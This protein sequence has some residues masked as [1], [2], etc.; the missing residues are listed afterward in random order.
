MR[1]QFPSEVLMANSVSNTISGGISFSGVSSGTD[2]TA[3]IEQLKQIEEI[4]KTRMTIWQ[5]EWEYRIAAMEEV[6]SVMSEGKTTLGGFDSVS[7]LMEVS[8]DSSEE[9]VATASL[10]LNSDLTSGNYSIDVKQVATPSLLSTKKIFDEK[11]TII[12]DSSE[13]LE[14]EYTYK[15]E[16]RTI[17]AHP[18]TTLDQLVMRINNDAQNPGVKASLIKNGDGYMFQIQGNDTGVDSELTIS[19]NLPDFSSQTQLF[20]GQDVLLNTTGSAKSYSV[21][22][23]G[24]TMTFDIGTDMTAEQFVEKFNSNGNNP[25]LTASL[26]RSGNDYIISYKD[27]KSGYSAN[28]TV[29]TEISALGGGTGYASADTVVNN[30]GTV[31]TLTYEYYGSNR[32]IQVANGATLQ[33]I[34][35]SINADPSN[36]S[37][38]EQLVQ[39]SVVEKD[40]KYVLDFITKDA[41]LHPEGATTSEVKYLSDGV[42]Y[43]FD[44]EGGTSVKDYIALFNKS[45][46][47]MGSGI[48]AELVDNKISYYKMNLG[49]KEVVTSS[50][51][52]E[53]DIPGVK[54]DMGFTMA[55]IP[56]D[57]NISSKLEG[58][59]KREVI[60]GKNTVVNTSGA[61][62]SYSFTHNGNNYSASVGNNATLEDFV[63]AFNSNPANSTL[64]ARLLEK[65][66]GYELAYFDMATG[67]QIVPEN[68]NTTMAHL[69]IGGDNWY[70]QESQDAIFSINGWPNEIT[71]SSNTLTEVIEGMNITIK[72][73]GETQLSIV[74][75]YTAMEENIYEI[76][77]TINLIKGTILKLQ[78]VDEEKE[79]NSPNSEELS[80]QFTWQSGAALTGNYG[81]QLLLSNFNTITSSA[82]EGFVRMEDPEDTLNDLYTALS[83]IGISTVTNPAEEDFGLLQV[84]TT[85]LQEAIEKDPLAIAE[86]FSAQLSGTTNSQDFTV[87]SAGIFAKAGTYDVDYTVNDAGVVTEVYINGSKAST[88]S[89]FPG[90]YTVSD[91]SNAALG[92]SVQFNTSG[93]APGSHSGAIQIKQGKVNELITF[94]NDELQR[95]DVEGEPQGTL[96]TIISN[97]NEIIDNLQLKIDRETDRIVNWEETEKLRFA[98]L[99]ETLSNY[100]ARTQLMSSMMPTT[101]S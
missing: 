93:L 36:Y 21:T 27:K 76:V 82:A 3:M 68:V 46:A 95:T 87:A 74:S 57:V 53:S 94:L 34:A 84:N 8:V 56:M 54:G 2:F 89:S 97:Y 88:D 17:T 85:E 33:D 30:T 73:V 45:A 42:E 99:E 25:G 43:S 11:T 13:A 40:G 59:G 24:E 37:N 50:I 78:E 51:S 9:E 16:T 22:Y 28:P 79:T 72:S 39:A 47:S 60:S 5:G 90:R 98:R 55:A 83:Q 71:S 69:Q 20:T 64:Q 41:T 18:G 10:T 81:V 61:P 23:G 12:N 63:T 48:S 91:S 86:L 52:L 6:L 66:S 101:T 26:E 7:E 100:E 35:D 80:S 29:N 96:P 49:A 92:V 67:E 58:L 62:A 70:E 1:Q 65:P 38:G 77:D 44:V 75:D 15:G 32:T 14:F 4:P 31:Q 19:S